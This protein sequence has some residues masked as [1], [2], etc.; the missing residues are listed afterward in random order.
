MNRSIAVL[1]GATA[2]FAST[3][4]YLWKQERAG[5]ERNAE[6]SARVQELER[7]SSR[8]KSLA[9]L[10]PGQP[11]PPDSG[12]APPQQTAQER[13]A[14]THAS[15]HI[16]TNVPVA[17]GTHDG[18][19]ADNSKLMSDPEYR[20]LM[21]AQS[22]WMLAERYA[23][24][25]DALQLRPDE[26]NKLLDLLADQE[27]NMMANMLPMQDQQ[28]DPKALQEWQQQAERQQRN[29]EAQIAALLG[30]A[31]MR[32]WKEYQSSEGARMQVNH[33]RQVLADS[34]EP[35]RQD[36]VQPLVKAIAAEQARRMENTQGTAPAEPRQIS[37][38]EEI[39]QLER[40]VADEIRSNERLHDTA[41]QHLSAQQLDE[42]DRVLQQGVDTQRIFIRMIRANEE[43]EKAGELPA[44]GSFA[45]LGQGIIVRTPP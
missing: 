30:D 22:R 33:L 14:L 3:S 39:E 16:E 32:Q 21:R 6:L 5:R 43:T 13:S 24:L 4:A 10:P 29:D 7:H 20:N 9:M 2:L 25:R 36:Q 12:I 26:A 27:A 18:F 31:K 34:S 17:F 44:Q 23:G 37:R 1:A 45:P 15:P 11:A 41:T 19:L 38:A 42:F 40:A 28:P 35:L 8:S